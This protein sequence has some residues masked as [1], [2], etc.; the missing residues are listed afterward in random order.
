M[1]DTPNNKAHKLRGHPVTRRTE[2]EIALLAANCFMGIHKN[3][4]NPLDA[5]KLI[6]YFSTIDICIHAMSDKEWDKKHTPY[7]KGESIPDLKHITIPKRLI[8]G[9][10]KNNPD[11][12]H[13]FFHEIGHV[14]LEHKPI[15]LKA[16]DN[17]IFQSMD[18]AE[19]QA[20]YFAK[21]MMRLL[22]I[23]PLPLGQLSFDF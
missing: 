11:D 1:T 15:Y 21:I 4:N 13:T 6:D 2:Q 18:D 9:T 17:Y 20:D 3:L 7:K 10:K 5:E 12:W 8:R 16:N 19:E 23:K 14:L 22:G